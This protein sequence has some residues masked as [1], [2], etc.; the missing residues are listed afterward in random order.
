MKCTLDIGYSHLIASKRRWN[1]CLGEL[2]TSVIVGEF[3]AVFSD[4]TFLGDKNL[5]KSRHLTGQSVSL[6]G[7]KQGYLVNKPFRRLVYRRRTPEAEKLSEKWTIGREARL[8]GQLWN[9]EDNLSANGITL[10]YTSKPARGFFNF[11][12]LWLISTTRM[13]CCSKEKKFSEEHNTF[14]AKQIQAG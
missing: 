11:I 12:I 5:W 14:A 4:K 2:S 1:N 3:F 10:R 8:R 6:K 13:L 9:F 7:K